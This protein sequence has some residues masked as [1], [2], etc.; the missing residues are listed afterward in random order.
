VHA[1]KEIAETGL[2]TPATDG[3]PLANAVAKSFLDACLATF[4]IGE[5]QYTNGAPIYYL[6][7]GEVWANEADITGVP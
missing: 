7:F 1:P 2:V 4:G 6:G 3:G 5:T